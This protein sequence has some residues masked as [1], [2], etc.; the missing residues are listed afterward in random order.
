MRSYIT[1]Y[2]PM[3]MNSVKVLGSQDMAA[4]AGG[5]TITIHEG[6]WINPKNGH[7]VRE[8]MWALKSFVADDRLQRLCKVVGQHVNDM[9]TLGEQSVMYELNGEAIFVDRIRQ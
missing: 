4:V 2:V 3:S 7:A 9:L 8:G 1:L 5:C 6:V